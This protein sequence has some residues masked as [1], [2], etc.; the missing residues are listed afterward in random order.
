M[1]ASLQQHACISTAPALHLSRLLQACR[2]L[3]AHLGLLN[4]V[5]PRYG[6]MLNVLQSSIL[7]LINLLLLLL[8][9]LGHSTMS[10]E[11]AVRAR[12]WVCFDG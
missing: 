2:P 4:Y 11:C 6:S 7:L 8:L 1:Q 5:H 12:V 10:C 9:L 3:K